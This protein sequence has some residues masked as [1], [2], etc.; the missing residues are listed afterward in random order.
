MSSISSAMDR[1]KAAAFNIYNLQNLDKWLCKNTFINGKPFNFTDR[2][3]QIDIL[4]DPKREQNVM[5]PAQVGLSEL[6]YRW[7]VGSCCIMDNFTVIYTFPTAGDATKNNQTRI[8]PMIDGSPEVKALV[9]Q[10]LNNS[11]VK[12]FG[13]NSFLFFKGTMADTAALSTPAD[14]LIHDEYDKSN[15]DVTTTYTSRLQDRET[16]IKKIFS[17]P[18]LAGYGIDKEARTSNRL[19]HFVKC[20]KC[21]QSFLPDYFNHVKIAGYDGSLEDITKEMLPKIKWEQAK[22]LCPHCG[23]DPEMHFS[24]MHWVN[25]NPDLVYTSNTWFVSPFSAHKR[26]SVPY[27]IESS[28]K[29][30]RYSEFKNQGLGLTAEEKNEAITENDIDTAQSQVIAHS[31][32]PHQMGVDF[33]MTCNITV[34]R[35]LDSGEVVVVYRERCHYTK[36]EERIALL[37]IE[38]NVTTQVLDSQPYTDIVNRVCAAHPHA[39]GAYYVTSKSPVPY[40]IKQQEEDEEEGKV[41]F[42]VVNVNRNVA[43]DEVLALIKAGKLIVSASAEND[44]FKKQMMSMKRVEKFTTAGE[45]QYVWTKTGDEQDHYHHSFLYLY[46]AIRMRHTSGIPGFA[47]AG[48]SPLFVVKSSR[49]KVTGAV[50][51]GS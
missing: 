15:L 29:Y 31:S 46:I 2:E 41:G 44:I 47:A 12:R 20:N 42:Q 38:F 40:Y 26:I 32:D 18:T 3:F 50:D 22:L 8:D 11:E 45:L 48:I 27:L 13:K 23:K 7:A 16:K 33:G 10:D 6:S 5:K 30:K 34:G 24:R 1:M 37:R 51:W 25:E 14:A 9:S 17:T 4:R 19:K 21:S 35:E 39:W 36:V 43:F 49:R 28:T